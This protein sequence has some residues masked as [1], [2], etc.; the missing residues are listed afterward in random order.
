MLLGKVDSSLISHTQVLGKLADKEHGQFIVLFQQLHDDWHWNQTDSTWF[1]RSSSSNEI[2]T[3]KIS[4][5]SKI[6]LVFHDTDNL[7]STTDTVFVDFH[8]TT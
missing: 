7:A 6:F 5:V 4:T 1:E 3:S 2:F 8:F